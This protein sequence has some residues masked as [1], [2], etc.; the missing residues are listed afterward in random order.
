MVRRLGFG[1]A[2]CI[3]GMFVTSING[4]DASA[5][6]SPQCDGGGLCGLTPGALR[7]ECFCY[8]GSFHDYT[9]T[10]QTNISNCALQVTRHYR[11]F[12]IFMSV[13]FSVLWAL[14]LVAL[15][16]NFYMTLK[17]RH[18]ENPMMRRLSKLANSSLIILAFFQIL[19][20]TTDFYGTFHHH[21]VW[22]S[23]IW[24]VTLYPLLLIIFSAVLG[25][26]IEIYSSAVA[27]LKKE[28]MLSKINSSYSKDITIEDVV[29]RVRFL[30]RLKWPFIVIVILGI[31]IDIV[32]VVMRAAHNYNEGVTITITWTA[33]YTFCWFSYSFGFIIYGYRLIR[34]LPLEVSTR[35]RELSRTITI[36]S[37]SLVL[38]WV[39][40]ITVN[41]VFYNAPF[42]PE[43]YLFLRGFF[44]NL[45]IVFLVYLLSSIFIRIPYLK[46]FLRH[47]LATV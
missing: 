17:H 5:D 10:A 41:T 24:E 20:W 2:L 32:Y 35:M 47:P 34:L 40:A 33:Y 23:F 29:D 15:A 19:F 9:L 38:L 21:P 26:W 3:M 13:F 18:L 6:C 39:V 44:V 14:L 36:T 22:V 46:A 27:T 8:D 4:Q 28:A 25:H 30:R 16:I 1:L 31:M 7:Y 42:G 45:M 43:M 11:D 37:L 12:V